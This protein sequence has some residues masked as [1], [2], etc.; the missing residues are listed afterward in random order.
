MT[1]RLDNFEQA[2]EPLIVR[3]G[4]TYFRSGRVTE[5]TDEGREVE[6]R[7]LGSEQYNVSMSVDDEGVIHHHRCSCPYEMGEFCKHEVAVL[8]RLRELR[9]AA[10]KQAKAQNI[11]GK[12]LEKR[13]QVLDSRESYKPLWERVL[14][15]LMQPE[16]A[17]PTEVKKSK[18]A[19]ERMAYEIERYGDRRLIYPRKQKIRNNGSWSEPLNISAQR[20]FTTGYDFMDDTDR[21]IFEHLRRIVG[22]TKY[23][24]HPNWGDLEDYLPYLVDTDKVLLSQGRTDVSLPVTVRK[25]R[26]YLNI[27][28]KRN[29]IVFTSN[30]K[31]GNFP[32]TLPSVIVVEESP[33][34]YVVIELTPYEQKVLDTLLRL[35]SMPMEAEPLL[36]QFISTI[37]NQLEIHSDMIEGGSTLE[38]IAGDTTL[39]LR[40]APAHGTFT[41][42]CRVQPLQGGRLRLFPAQGKATIYDE[43]DGTRY[44]VERNIPEEQARLI[45][46][47]EFAM[48][49]LNCLFTSEP[50][51]L[52]IE[53]I[54]TLM[55]FVSGQN[56]A[57][58]LEWLEGAKITVKQPENVDSYSMGLR[59]RQN[60]FEVEG[61]LK[62]DERTI[63]SAAELLRMAQGNIVG[64]RFVRLSDSEFLALNERLMKQLT[65]V[66]QLAHINKN[67]VIIPRFEIGLL[68]ELISNPE[69]IL[70]EDKGVRELL[71]KIEQAAQTT[72]PVPQNLQATLRDYQEEGY[73]WMMRLAEWGAGA[74]L[75]DDMGLG[76]T[77]QTIAVMLARA[78]K[79]AS[80]V[81][82][83]ASVLYNWQSELQ[84]FA[85]TL[86][87]HICNEADDRE[88]LIRS[89][90]AYDVLLTT[91]G[92]LVREE[93]QLTDRPWNVVCL[94]EAHTIKNRQTKMSQAAMCLRADVRLALT[95]T[96]LQNYLSELWNL[97][98]FIN[99]GLL[100]SYETFSHDFITPIEVNHDKQRQ[101]TLR[102]ILQP[103]LLRRT[104]AEVIDELPEKTEIIRR[105]E[106]S[107]EE[108][109]AYEAMRIEAQQHLEQATKVDVNVLASITRLRQ[110]ADSDSKLEDFVALLTQIVTAGNRVLVFSQFTTFLSAAQHSLTS[111]SQAI[112]LPAGEAGLTSFYLD[113]STPLAKRKQLVERF[114]HGEAQVFFISLKAGGLGLNLT[115]ANYVIHLDPWW[116][117]AIEQQ[118]TDRA[119]RIGQHRNVTVY[120]LIAADTIEEKILRLHK[121]KRDL[122][123][124]LLHDQ[125]TAQTLTLDDLKM[126]LENK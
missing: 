2:I 48:R 36:R 75:A 64:K 66:Q 82:A 46:L 47:N 119:Y 44:H 109:I 25:E 4:R 31:I 77:V 65:R 71:R 14:Q 76:K 28:R 123:D 113:G 67:T 73:R 27:E 39:L 24:Y 19:R 38:H 68:G 99:P 80:L 107:A 34:E 58:A 121:T 8:Y 105:V 103:F 21:K 23:Y 126:L 72:F 63:L 70:R 17:N 60:W 106:L 1:I 9:N 124:A 33:T 55:E 74:C 92:L 11:V 90:Q 110:A 18:K 41:V 56:E 120:H 81:V 3:R 45:A 125:N 54:L 91:Y 20:Y 49:E 10:A 13:K 118:A 7:V 62:L 29:T 114:Q 115:G 40:I 101:K 116:N 97:F 86:N 69:T 16:Q 32:S 35:G 59:T 84:R 85:P 96:P 5:C 88:Q 52:E 95:G 112:T 37:S 93:K 15:E 111:R 89:M 83:P 61:E 26:A 78:D 79:G 12:M 6:A 43:K 100:G 51:T 57:Y 30:V 53:D 98:Q 94:D 108:R 104:K 117:P 102:Q 50:Q 22:H 122:A 42:E 87:V